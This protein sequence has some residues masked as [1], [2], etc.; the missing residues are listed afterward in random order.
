MFFAKSLQ[1]ITNNSNRIVLLGDFHQEEKN[2]RP[3][4]KREITK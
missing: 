2:K 3:S 1:L 4:T